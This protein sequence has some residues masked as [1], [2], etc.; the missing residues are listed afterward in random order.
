M[1]IAY[2][3]DA[4]DRLIRFNEAWS[5]FAHANR[6]EGALPHAVLRKKLWDFVRDP[7]LQELYRRLVKR[8]RSGNPVRF[9]YRCDAPSER[10]IF[11]MEIRGQKD[12]VVEF[13]STLTSV[14][15]RSSVAWLDSNV[16]HDPQLLVRVCSWCSRVALPDNQWVEIERA[17]EEHQALHGPRIPSTTHG[18]CPECQR[19]MFDLLRRQTGAEAELNRLPK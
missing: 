10:R 16:L 9:R 8:S 3:I 12:G 11:T 7:T 4:E 19:Q 15:P 14:E 13:I 2:T 5:D 18:I 17:I 6:G 1:V